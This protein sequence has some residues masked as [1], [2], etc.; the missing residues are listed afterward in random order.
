MQIK[1]RAIVYRVALALFGLFL[2]SCS[3][4]VNL[5]DIYARLDAL[6]SSQ[7][8]SESQ[9]INAIKNSIGYLESVNNE[10]STAIRELEASS[11]ASSITVQIATLKVKK[12]QLESDIQVLKNYVNSTP[13]NWI[14]TTVATL[15]QY[16][17]VV[18]TLTA[19]QA[20][21]A[22]LKAIVT[23]NSDVTSAIAAAEASMKTWVNSQLTGYWTIGQTQAKLD[24]LQTYVNNAIAGCATPKDIEDL[25]QEIKDLTAALDKAKT[26]IKS[27]YEN[28]ISVAIATL[29][30]KITGDIANAISGANANVATLGARVDALEARVAALEADVAE[31]LGMIQSVSVIPQYSDGSV[32]IK[33]EDPVDICFEVRP[34][35]AAEKLKNLPRSAFSLG[36]VYTKTKA[37][38]EF[39]PISIQSISYKDGLVTLSV[40]GDNLSYGFFA[41]ET[42]ANARLLIE[43]GKNSISSSFFALSPVG[44][45]RKVVDMG[46]SVEWAACNLGAES[47]QCFGNYYRWAEI[48]PMTIYSSSGYSSS[49]SYSLDNDAAHHALGGSWRLPTKQE[50]EDLIDLNNSEIIKSTD[51]ITIKSKKTGSKLFFPK[52]GYYASSSGSNIGKG[53]YY[54]SSDKISNSDAYGLTFVNTS[55][56]YISYN[57][58]VAFY[59]IRPVCD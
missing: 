59:S 20:D 9:Q 24:V 51:G 17:N 2:L 56:P 53:G 35:I 26:D 57:Q 48:T 44:P 7:I 10:L 8:A 11:S 46:L 22:S 15:T 55:D 19:I 34:L 58:R 39:I 4:K 42:A 43:S 30:G 6:E 3:S 12:V 31:I 41:F 47:P 54:W 27:E 13:T 37:S 52:A 49:L 5:D 1:G 29:D 36:A 45:H 40:V 14:S 32:D 25:Q 33:G 28:A 50:F 18:L 38:V 16:N 23:T 21:V